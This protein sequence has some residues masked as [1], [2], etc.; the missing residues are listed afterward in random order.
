MILTKKKQTNRTQT[1]KTI[2][3]LSILKKCKNTFY[4]STDP[5]L[6]LGQESVSTVESSAECYETLKFDFNFESLSVILYNRDMNQVCDKGF[7]ML[8]GWGTL[9]MDRTPDSKI[10]YFICCLDLVMLALW[11]FGNLSFNLETLSIEW[12]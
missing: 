4:L 2:P 6:A 7:I 10:K 3:K 12:P 9:H 8:L 11:I 5:L 1:Q